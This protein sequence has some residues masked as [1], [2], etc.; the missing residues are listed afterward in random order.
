MCVDQDVVQVMSA[1][2]L[3]CMAVDCTLDKMQFP[4][5]WSLYTATGSARVSVLRSYALLW[6]GMLPRVSFLH[7]FVEPHEPVSSQWPWHWCLRVTRG[8]MPLEQPHSHPS[9]GKCRWAPRIRFGWWRRGWL[10]FTCPIA[11]VLLVTAVLTAP[12]CVVATWPHVLMLAYTHMSTHT[13]LHTHF[14]LFGLWL[15]TQYFILEIT[16]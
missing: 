4:R 9:W 6:L 11:S 5:R 14:F 12:F 15:F 10:C 7:T 13:Y 3:T 8:L 16:L 1:H 2:W